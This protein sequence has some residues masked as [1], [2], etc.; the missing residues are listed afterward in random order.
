MRFAF[1]RSFV[2]KRAWHTWKPALLARLLAG[3]LLSWATDA[4]CLEFWTLHVMRG[5]CSSVTGSLNGRSLSTTYDEAK[6]YAPLGLESAK[7]H[8]L[9]GC[10]RTLPRDTLCRVNAGAPRGWALHGGRRSSDAR[11]A[12]WHMRSYTVQK[13]KHTPLLSERQHS[14]FARAFARSWCML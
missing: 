2:P 10:V 4:S 11:K 8:A 14:T 7:E 3:A 1:A 12:I 13:P 6:R 5:R 9:Q